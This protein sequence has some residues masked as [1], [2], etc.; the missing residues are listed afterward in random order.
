MI[1]LAGTEF[2]R[3][4]VNPLKVFWDIPGNFRYARDVYG[5]ISLGRRLCKVLDEAGDCISKNHADE[6]DNSGE[7]LSGLSW[8]HAWVGKVGKIGKLGKVVGLLMASTQTVPLTAVWMLYLVGTHPEVRQNLLV[9]LNG[10]GAAHADY[11]TAELLGKLKYA[12]AV[13]RE[14]LRLF[15]PFP[16]I[17]REAQ[18]DDNLCGVRVTRGTP[19]YVVP[20]LIHRNPK[21]W[22]E[23]DEFKPQRFIGNEA[24]GD[25]ASDWVYLPFGRGSRMCAGS[26]LAMM[27]L[28]VLLACAVLGYDWESSGEHESGYGKFPELGMVP[29]GIELRMRSKAN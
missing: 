6:N 7:G 25:G 18:D 15:P 13:I 1:G 27:E 8:V 23:A 12:D 4:M 14:T 3:R 2:A 19:V 16:L 11:L 9:E 5:L 10:V 21:F 24:H 28:K 29:K 20:W 26:R 22:P 17:Q